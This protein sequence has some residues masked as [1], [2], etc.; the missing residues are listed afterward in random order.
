MKQSAVAAV[1]YS[2]IQEVFCLNFCWIGGYSDKS[3]IW[4]SGI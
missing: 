4:S 3:K 1:L 2:G